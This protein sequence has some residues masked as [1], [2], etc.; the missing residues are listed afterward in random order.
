MGIDIL[1]RADLVVSD[2]LHTHILCVLLGIPQVALD[3]SYQKIKR[4]S[5]EWTLDAAFHKSINT[6][7][8]S[9]AVDAFFSAVPDQRIDAL[10]SV[11]D[12]E[13]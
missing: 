13:K 3:N 6:T 2:R 8:A 9:R 7:D 12:Q 5:D 1:S 11:R 10:L 4:Y